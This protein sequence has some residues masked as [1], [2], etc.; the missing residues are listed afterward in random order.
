MKILI[1][2]GFEGFV[3][4]DIECQMCCGKFFFILDLVIYEVDLLKELQVVFESV[5]VDYIEM[6]VVLGCELQKFFKGL[7]NVCV[8]F[9]FY[10]VVIV[11][12]V[13]DDV[14]FND[15]VVCFFECYLYGQGDVYNVII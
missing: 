3:E 13:Y 1:F 8:S 7:F 5:V 2:C 12:V 6:C 4:I 15:V 10:W 14:L 11:C 9:E